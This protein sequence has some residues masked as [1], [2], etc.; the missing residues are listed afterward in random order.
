MM[1]IED[2]AK[3]KIVRT[4]ALLDLGWRPLP[5]DLVWSQSNKSKPNFGGPRFLAPITTSQKS[6][7]APALPIINSTEQSRPPIDWKTS[8][9][10]LTPLKVT[11][12]D[13]MD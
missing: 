5:L 10:W 9:Q 2:R 1:R 4:D 12:V 6:T 7:L 11:N 8:Q 13:L 3:K